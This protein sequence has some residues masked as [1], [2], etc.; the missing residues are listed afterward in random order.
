M[1]LFPRTLKLGLFFFFPPF[2]C[3][4][5]LLVLLAVAVDV[6]RCERA[7]PSTWLG[8]AAVAAAVVVVVVFFFFFYSFSQ[9][10]PPAVLLTVES[11]ERDV[12][13]HLNS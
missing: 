1:I 12:I 6:R 5:T 4:K 13:S 11:L 2:S 7:V 10:L 9:N 8:V 3:L